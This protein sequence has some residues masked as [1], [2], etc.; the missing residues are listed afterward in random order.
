[1]HIVP[2]ELSGYEWDKYYVGITGTSVKKRWQ[3]NGIGY[4]NQ[5]FYRAIKKYGW[6]NIKH[7]VIKDNI[8]LAEAEEL[9]KN[10]ISK[11]KSNFSKF[12]YN[13]AAGGYSGGGVCK[14][15]AQYDLDGNLLNV[16]P[17]G[18]EALRES[19]GINE[20]RLYQKLVESGKAYGYMWRFFDKEP[21]LKIEPYPGINCKKVLQYDIYGNFIKE[22]NSLKEAET[23]YNALNLIGR[24]C[25]GKGR[26][27]CGYQWKYASDDRE[28]RDISN[29]LHTRKRK[30]RIF[31][32]TLSGEFYNKYYSKKEAMEDLNLT[33]D[34][35]LSKFTKE[36]DN[37]EYQGYRWCVKYYE[38]LPPLKY[39]CINVKHK[40]CPV[41]Q[42]SVETNEI[43]NI[44]ITTKDAASSVSSK[45]RGS[46]IS[47]CC[48]NKN[49]TAYGYK[50]KFIQDVNESDFTDSFL[51]QKYKSINNFLDKQSH[52]DKRS[53]I[54][55]EVI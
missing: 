26:V 16:F 24:V 48:K 27:S 47:N 41:V 31:I 4:K 53:K 13:V 19:E 23:Y 1:M 42:I 54:D 10:L 7:I 12:G 40:V 15:I 33:H 37:N 17:S 39:D 18:A 6:N 21:E 38:K 55:M 14:N 45:A 22:W 29:D 8:T 25:K 51:L 20:P 11:Y 46:N 52:D 50:W 3:S 5:L 44:F 32:Y 35:I 43:I 34:F 28:I 9:E 30:Y 2:K 49:K 36:I